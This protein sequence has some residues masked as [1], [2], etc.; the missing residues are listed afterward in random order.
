MRQRD[1]GLI[2]LLAFLWGCS[3][4]LMAVSLESL[5][6]LT[7]AFSRLALAGL[8]LAGFVILVKEPIVLD[9]LFLYEITILGLL[10]AALPITLI[11]WAQTRIDSGVAG[12]LNSTSAL[13]TLIVAHIL[14]DNEKITTSKLTGVVLGMAGVALIMGADAIRGLGEEVFGQLAM[15]GAT[16]CYGFANVYGRR[17]SNRNATV[18]AAGMLLAGALL[19]LPI[20]AISDWPLTQM[21][22]V[23]SLSALVALAALSTACAFVVWFKL[24]RS[25]GPGNTVLVTFLIPPIAL[26]LGIFFLNES[27]DVSD[28]AGL[29]LI[30]V[31]LWFTQ[32]NFSAKK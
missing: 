12:I 8:L 2:F 20:A 19:L 32:Q 15:L 23:R 26:L 16:L 29:A 18:S 10:R 25:V 11:L 9:R 13:F 28:L 7:T 3:F 6:I 22:S 17:F 31:G 14:T 30:A 27:P 4:L 5:P 21:P 24:I 1:W